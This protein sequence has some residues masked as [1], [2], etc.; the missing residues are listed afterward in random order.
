MI[1]EKLQKYLKSDSDWMVLDQYARFVPLQPGVPVPRDKAVYIP[2]GKGGYTFWSG[3]QSKEEVFYN[4]P[5]FR[6]A[7]PS[8]TIFGYVYNAI[9]PIDHPHFNIV[10]IPEGIRE[11]QTAISAHC[12]IPLEG[13]YF[14]FRSMSLDTFIEGLIDNTQG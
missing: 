13:V 12:T 6:T 7:F 3:Q 11:W 5:K 10:N 9:P 14:P 1:N 2:D 4:E 8:K